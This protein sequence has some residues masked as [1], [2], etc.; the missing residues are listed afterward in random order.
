M[1]D[2]R[3]RVEQLPE[4]NCLDIPKFS[5]NTDKPVRAYD[6]GLEKDKKNNSSIKT[7]SFFA[8]T[9]DKQPKKFDRVKKAI[10][11]SAIIDIGYFMSISMSK[12]AQISMVLNPNKA[13][14][15]EGSFF[16]GE[17][18]NLTPSSYFKKN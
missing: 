9:S 10:K 1:S 18:A 4:D 15:F 16:L 6:C 8:T 11:F 13:G 14:L 12:V 2:T 17:G 7:S 5:M 3:N